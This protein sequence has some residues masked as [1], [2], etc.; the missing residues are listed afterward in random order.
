MKDKKIIAVVGATGQQGS[1]LV[2]AILQD[3]NSEFAV[4]ALTRDTTSDAARKLAGVGADVVH[5]NLDDPSSVKRAFEGAYGAFCVTFFWDHHSPERE[6]QQAKTMAEAA[7]AAGLKHVIWS[8]LEDSRNWMA[9]S[10]ERMPTLMGKYK[11]PHCDSKGESDAFFR[12]AGVPTT[13]LLTSF[14]WENFIYFGM[15]PQR[16]G[17]GTLALTFPLGDAKLPGI[18]SD[19]IGRCAYTIFREGTQHV[20]KTIGIAGEHLT[21]QQMAAA[22]SDVLGVPVLYNEVSP[23]VY[24]NFGFDGAEDLGNMFQFKSDFNSDFCNA[25][26]VERS[27]KLNP[28][29]K[30]FR[31]WLSEN[32]DRIPLPE[33][34]AA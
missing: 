3:K 17:D 7:R 2:R 19:D 18:A 23:A 33:P 10:D 13:F 24:R 32:K 12:E 9:L 29:L 22:F 6:K 20:G 25:R 27:R 14:Y 11:I 5:A 1:G 28:E 34:V 4:R 15:G 21:C 26:S 8:T 30:T 16:T 31:Q